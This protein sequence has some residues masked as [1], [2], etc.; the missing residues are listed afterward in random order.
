MIYR[1][2]HPVPALCHVV[3]YYWYASDN[4]DITGTQYFNTTLLQTLA[5]NFIDKNDKHSF[6]GKTHNLNEVAYFFGQSTCP[7]KVDTEGKAL[8]MIGV[9]FKPTGIAR[10]TGI[11]MQNIADN[12]ISAEAIWGRELTVLN[13]EIQSTPDIE[14]AVLVLEVFL[15]KKMEKI[16]LMPRMD[17]IDYAL[18][19]I[20]NH[21]GN[22]PIQ[23][24]QYQTNTSRKTFERSFMQSIGLMPKLYS[25]II[26]FNVAKALMNANPNLSVSDIAFDMGYYDNSHFAANF[27]RFCGQKP[28][29]Y[30]GAEPGKQSENR[31]F[32]VSIPVS[33]V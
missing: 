1:V 22:I 8:K 23:T 24:L 26:R 12:I 3:D 17:S 13:D 29:A 9:K 32:E 6:N 20:R 15:L 11:P 28:T 25:E 21:N 10:I 16:K 14:N 27:K 31:Y 5:F 7:R 18:S 30:M 2:F 33:S 19:L 4:Q